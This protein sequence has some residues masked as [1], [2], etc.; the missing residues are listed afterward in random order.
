MNNVP[1]LGRISLEAA[2]RLSSLR[3]R[4]KTLDKLPPDHCAK[5]ALEIFTEI[6]LDIDLTVHITRPILVL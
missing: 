6:G 1:E 4:F 5:A 3:S 2:K